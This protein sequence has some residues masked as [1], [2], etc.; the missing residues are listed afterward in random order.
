LKRL[1]RPTSVEGIVLI[2]SIFTAIT[3]IVPTFWSIVLAV[4]IASSVSNPFSI[5]DFAFLCINNNGVTSRIHA[6]ESKRTIICAFF[7]MTS[8]R[9]VFIACIVTAIAEIVSAGFGIVW[10]PGVAR[11]ISE[12]VGFLDAAARKT[13]NFLESVCAGG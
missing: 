3:P 9:R 13:F 8:I 10:L 11:S 7:R 5:L 4:C 6:K 12:I 1:I 2:A